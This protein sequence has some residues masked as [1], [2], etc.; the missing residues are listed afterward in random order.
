AGIMAPIAGWL[1]ETQ[2]QRTT[3]WVAGGMILLLV[4]GGILLARPALRLKA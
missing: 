2:G 3:Y 4:I 1:Y